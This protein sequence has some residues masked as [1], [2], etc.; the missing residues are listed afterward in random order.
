MGKVNDWEAFTSYNE[1]MKYPVLTSTGLEFY[2]FEQIKK[3]GLAKIFDFPINFN[4]F[5]KLME[6]INCI[7]DLCRKEIDSNTAVVISPPLYLKNEE[8]ER[9]TF[10]KAF[11]DREDIY[12]SKI[13]MIDVIRNHKCHKTETS[14]DPLLPKGLYFGSRD[15]CLRNIPIPI[16]D[17]KCGFRNRYLGFIEINQ[18]DELLDLKELDKRL[19]KRYGSKFR[20]G[21]FL[22]DPEDQVLSV[23]IDNSEKILKS[24]KL[25]AL[26]SRYFRLLKTLLN[27]SP[28]D[29][30]ETSLTIGW[31][32]SIE[33][34]LL[35][36]ISVEITPHKP[37]NLRN[38]ILWDLFISALQ[39]IRD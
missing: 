38:E 7:K 5:K 18:E 34:T 39:S 31:M 2:S 1:Q 9:I 29:I 23:L 14:L 10:V 8:R 30:L 13:N 6:K 17:P 20:M 24:K 15:K 28:L 4:D 21:E 16:D 12:Y 35:S 25:R 32:S 37:I 11:C 27:I 19:V 3:S 36:E 26:I 33:Q 22:L